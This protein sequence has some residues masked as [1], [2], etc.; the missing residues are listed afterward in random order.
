MKTQN[1]RSRHFKQMTWITDMLICLGASGLRVPETLRAAMALL[2]DAHV[3]RVFIY[4]PDAKA[5]GNRVSVMCFGMDA[6]DCE[7]EGE[8]DSVD[9]LPDW[10]KERLAVL[11]VMPSTPPT[12]ELEG[13]G[14][15]I[16]ASVFWVHA[17]KDGTPD[18]TG[19]TK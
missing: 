2:P 5:G 18:S 15:R 6:V 4:T 1:P 17:P 11:M 7:L 12:V 19:E 3:Y 13:V 10:V 14:R 9:E 8:Y 16:S